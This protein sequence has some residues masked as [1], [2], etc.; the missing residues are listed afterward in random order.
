MLAKEKYI[1]H[2]HGKD[3]FYKN[4]IQRYSYTVLIDICSQI[5]FSITYAY[6]FINLCTIIS[7]FIILLTLIIRIY[8]Y[9]RLCSLTRGL[10]SLNRSHT[11]YIPFY[12]LFAL[13]M[14]TMTMMIIIMMMLTMNDDG[15]Y[16]DLF[17]C[18]PI[19]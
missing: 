6:I 4:L 1:E 7:L 9:S 5:Y 10:S 11:A 15:D 18:Y 2:L 3:C 16:N 17:V 14:T 19:Q 13:L 8:I 12:S